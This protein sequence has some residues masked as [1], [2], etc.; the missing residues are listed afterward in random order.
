MPVINL[1]SIKEE[2][3]KCFIDKSRI[4]M[5]ENYFKTD[6]ASI[7]M[8]VPFILFPKQREY[9]LNLSENTHNITVKPRQSGFSTVTCAKIACEMALGDSDSPV[10][11]LIITNQ[12]KMA[13]E[14]LAK[15]KNFLLQ[16]PRWFFGQNYFSEDPKDPRLTKT[17]F[18]RCTLQELYLPNGAN[19]HARSSGPNAS[20]GISS[21]NI[22]FVD[23]AAFVNNGPEVFSAAIRTTATVKNKLVCVVSTPNGM[24]ELYFGIYD[25]ALKGKN[26]YKIT[27]LKWYHDPRFNRN[28]KWYKE[29]L[30]K[31]ENGEEYK[32]KKWITEE[33]IDSAGHIKYDPEKWKGLEGKGYKPYNEWYK[34]SCQEVNNDPLLIAREIECS[35]SGSSRI[36][37]D[38]AVIEMHRN[39]NVSSK[40]RT[41]PLNEDTWIWKEPVSG[42]KYIMGMDISRGD[43]GDSSTIEILDITATD[44]KNMPCIDQVLEYV[45]KVAGDT[46]G[47]FAYNYGLIYNSAYAI[48]D[49]IGGFG[50]A[51]T[52]TLLRMNYP[53]LYYDNIG[54][55]DYLVDPTYTTFTPNKDGQ[56]PGFHAKGAR[57]FMITNFISKLRDNIIKIRSGRVISELQT[58]EV[59]GN[60]KIEHAGGKHDDTLTNLSM[61][62]FVYENNFLK[63]EKQRELDS[64]ILKSF[65]RS[66]ITPQSTGK[67][68]MIKTLDIN[69]EYNLSRLYSAKSDDMAQN[70]YSWYFMPR[71]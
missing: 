16:L 11:A 70:P 36:A 6:D 3:A 63:I 71:I 46:L 37:V 61:I 55:K 38:P 17:I 66:L 24:D 5:I 64:A 58:W 41:D 8:E 18:T 9:L 57:T 34:I 43:A 52:L 22:L 47:E 19:L 10:T 28:L 44:E 32:D 53:N 4:Y 51:T 50:E 60:G 20:R 65:S 29:I 54:N 1:S 30:K 15:V 45:G 26:N 59:K 33:T 21:T 25:N 35:F 13:Q 31:D 27:E 39:L 2:Y 62:L 56:L 23:E 42:H 68:S 14:D 69:P 48:A 40:Y 67:S 12:M 49:C 7:G